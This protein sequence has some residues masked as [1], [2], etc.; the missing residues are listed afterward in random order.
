MGCLKSSF[1]IIHFGDKS[2]FSSIVFI[3]FDTLTFSVQ[4][5]SKNILT[6]LTT[7]IA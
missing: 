7:H 5:Q 4:K 2:N 3:I 1:S 6:G